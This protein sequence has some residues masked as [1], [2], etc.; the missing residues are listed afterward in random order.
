MLIGGYGVYNTLHKLRKSNSCN[1]YRFIDL[2]STIG[3]D[4]VEI[5]SEVSYLKC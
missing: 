3:Y 4:G 1:H 5:R 2:I